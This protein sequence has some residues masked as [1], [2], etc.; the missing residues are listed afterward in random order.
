MKKI[1]LSIMICLS[2]IFCL[3]I[4]GTKIMV[5]DGVIV[6]EKYPEPTTLILPLVEITLNEK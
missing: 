6:G 2:I 3:S 5:D 4:L 1:A